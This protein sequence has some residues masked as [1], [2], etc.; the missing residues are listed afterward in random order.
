MKY[1]NEIIKEINERGPIDVESCV[2]DKD[3]EWEKYMRG[4]IS[5]GAKDKNENN[6]RNS[7]NGDIEEK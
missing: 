2:Y 3:D 5:K 1:A 4:I 6:D 7:I